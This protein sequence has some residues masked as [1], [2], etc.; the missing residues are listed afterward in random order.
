MSREARIYVGN[1]SSYVLFIYSHLIL[2]LMSLFDSCPYCCRKR[3]F[4]FFYSSWYI[5]YIVV[6][7][8]IH[9]IIFCRVLRF[10]CH[11]AVVLFFRVVRNT[12]DTNVHHIHPLFYSFKKWFSWI[13]IGEF[14]F[15]FLSL[16]FFGMGILPMLEMYNI[17]KRRNGE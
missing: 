3:L 12:I 4:F 17:A 5:I 2:F 16:F 15:S 14:C 13:R 8:L 6:M 9:W 1:L 10:A 7:I 11:S